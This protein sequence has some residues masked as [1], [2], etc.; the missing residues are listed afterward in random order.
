MG[1]HTRAASQAR[2][3]AGRSVEPGTA[4]SAAANPTLECE[5]SQNGFLVDAPQ[6]QSENGRFGSVYSLP[7]QSTSVTSSPSTRRDRSS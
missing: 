1:G 7:S 4:A 5:P 3:Y 2:R 6:R